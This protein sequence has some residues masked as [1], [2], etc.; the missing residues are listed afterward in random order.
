MT[1]PVTEYAN[2]VIVGKRV[3]CLWVR[4][5]CERHMRDMKD[6]RFVWDLNEVHARLKM[7][8]TVRHYKG[9]WK[10]KPFKPDPWQKFIIG[11]LF[12]WKLKT[13]GLRRYRYAF[14]KVPRK[15]GKT[16]LAA[17]IALMM[18]IAGGQ[19]GRSGRF[20]TE[21]GAEVYFVATKEDQAKIG[22]NDCVK[23]IKRSPGWSDRLNSR[24]KEIRCD[25]NDGIC[26]PLGSDSDSL[27]GL[28]PSCAVKDELHAWKDRALWDQIDD[29]FGAREQPLDF[30]ITTEGV[31]RNGIHDEIDKHARDILKSDGTY[32][33]ETFFAMIW[34]PDEGDDPFDERTWFKANPNLGVSKGLDYMRD[35]A[36]KARLMP[37][38]LSAF[39]TKQLN[40]R[41]DRDE[42]WLSINQWDACKGVVNLEALKGVDSFGAIDLGRVGDW[43]SFCQVFPS[44]EQ[45]YEYDWTYWIPEATYDA[46]KREGR[47]PVD[48]WKRTGS[49]FV[50]DG[51][52]TDF[53]TIEAFIAARSVTHPMREFCYDPMFAHELAMRLR[54]NHG[55]NVVEFRQTFTN[56]TP[57]CSQFER[58]LLAG[59]MRHNGHPVAR[60]NAGNVVLRKGPSGNM[61]PDKNK[62]A[63]KIDGM[64]AAL[65]ATGRAIVA[66]PP[67]PPPAVFF[68]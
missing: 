5:A 2:Q 33:D 32:V 60:W 29:A 47:I 34:S 23:I 50:T 10:G 7:C 55:L 68:V 8:E 22:W 18:L 52:V 61:M 53:A 6:P 1:D 48:V 12:G 16:W 44:A 9:E 37:G 62:S 64:S 42:T 58:M 24:V 45:I 65:M 31:I 28:N 27:D 57:A 41:Q 20:D 63:A 40:L 59:Q 46:L 15:N 30:I 66:P 49:L 17:V 21:G 13:K 54:D 43:S 36:A 11:S 38:K 35:Q 39:L 26:R 3:E 14:V 4:Q 67:P 51:N 19:L 56:Y 25:A